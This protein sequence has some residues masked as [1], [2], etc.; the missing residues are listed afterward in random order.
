MIYSTFRNEYFE[1]SYEICTTV[2]GI[3]NLFAWINNRIE[4]ERGNCSKKYEEEQ[5]IYVSLHLHVRFLESW[6]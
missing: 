1:K 3:C 4:E 2:N 6:Q 5:K